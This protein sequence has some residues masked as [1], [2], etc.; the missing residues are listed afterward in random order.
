[1]SVL[2]HEIFLRTDLLNDAALCDVPCRKNWGARRCG[3]V[4]EICLRLQ[5]S[6][7]RQ[8]QY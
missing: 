7:P 2:R 4:E 1:M 3:K 6:A 8:W 5:D